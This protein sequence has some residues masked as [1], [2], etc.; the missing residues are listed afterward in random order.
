MPCA[1]HCPALETFWGFAG[2]CWPPAGSRGRWWSWGRFSAE[3]RGKSCRAGRCPA[4]GALSWDFFVSLTDVLRALRAPGSIFRGRCGKPKGAVGHLCKTG[5]EI[6]SGVAL[7]WSQCGAKGR[8][9]LGDAVAFWGWA[10]VTVSVL[11]CLILKSKAELVFWQAYFGL[12][13][14]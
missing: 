6:Y 8:A 2:R 14:V 11:V 5:A 13:S 3:F 7:G 1:R 4:P 10:N 12:F 9:R